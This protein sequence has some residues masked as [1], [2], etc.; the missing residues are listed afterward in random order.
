M[1]WLPIETAPRDGTLYLTIEGPYMWV[2]NHPKGHYAGVW[3]WNELRGQWR[4]HAHADDRFPTHWMP[5]PPPP[6][7]TE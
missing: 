2:E 1:K 3:S 5:L 4:G 6:E 7:K